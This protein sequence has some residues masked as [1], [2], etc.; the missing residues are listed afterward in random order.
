MISVRRE[1]LLSFSARSKGESVGW[2]VGA[3][4][5]GGLERWP[6]AR[7]C[8]TFTFYFEPVTQLRRAKEITR[9]RKEDREVFLSGLVL[10]SHRHAR[11]NADATPVS[12]HICGPK[13]GKFL[14]GDLRGGW[15]WRRMELDG[16]RVFAGR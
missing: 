6:S 16:M 1:A 4:G 5:V 12:L 14:G 11:W 8:L 9:E 15:G 10:I 2:W 13:D 3:D 7:L